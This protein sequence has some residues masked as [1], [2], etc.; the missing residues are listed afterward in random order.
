MVEKFLQKDRKRDSRAKHLAHPPRKRD[1]QTV[2]PLSE[3]YL[4]ICV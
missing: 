4:A 3:N 1:N 2:H